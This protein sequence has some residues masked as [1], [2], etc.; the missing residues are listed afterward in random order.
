MLIQM[1]ISLIQKL[2]RQGT[3]FTS[4]E[5]PDASDH[6]PLARAQPPL[7][8]PFHIFCPAQKTIAMGLHCHLQATTNDTLA[9]IILHSMPP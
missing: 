9:Y 7:R 1:N 8:M 5:F 4:L 3:I 6:K 2:L